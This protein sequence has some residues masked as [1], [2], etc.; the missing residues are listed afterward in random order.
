MFWGSCLPFCFKGRRDEKNSRWK[1]QVITVHTSDVN[2]LGACVSVSR[3][4]NLIRCVFSDF[5]FQGHVLYSAALTC[6]NESVGKFLSR[7][8]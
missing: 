5:C 2:M 7:I 8:L 1:L 6:R 3:L 4:R